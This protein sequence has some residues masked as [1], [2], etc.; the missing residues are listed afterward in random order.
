MERVVKGSYSLLVTIRWG[1]ILAVAEE[2]PFFKTD[3][4]LLA[5]RQII[6]LVLNPKLLNMICIDTTI[7]RKAHLNRLI[8]L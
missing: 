2:T 7:A 4:Y 6:I 5:D 3:K 8:V 1:G